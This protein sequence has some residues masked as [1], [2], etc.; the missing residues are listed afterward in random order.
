MPEQPRT[1]HIE[2]LGPPRGARGVQE[3][4]PVADL[5]DLTTHH[6]G[7]NRAIHMEDG[8]IRGAEDQQPTYRGGDRSYAYI[9]GEF[10]EVID[11]TTDR[12]GSLKPDQVL[13]VKDYILEDPAPP[14]G[15][16]ARAVG[17]PSPTAGYVSRVS[18]AGG[19]V[20]IMDREGGDVIARIR[21]LDPISV[22]EGDTV[23]YG[24]SLGTQ[25]NKGL[26]RNAGVH[27]HVEMDTAHHQQLVD[28]FDD[29]NSG[30]L[31]VQPE[32]RANTARPVVADGTFRLGQSDERIGDVQRVM[33]G[34]GY[35]A[36]DG[37]VLD[38]DGV[39][40]PN[41]QGALLDFQRDHGLPQ[42]GNI[43]P[44]TLDLAPP[45]PRRELDGE[46]G[47][48]A[49]QAPPAHAAP[50]HPDHPDHG[51]ALP[52]QPAPAVNQHRG[53]H[54][55]RAEQSQVVGE[56][57]A[58]DRAMFEKLRDRIPGHIS[59]DAVAAALHGAKKADIDSAE[60]I[61]DVRLAGDQIYVVGTTPGFRAVVDLSQKIPA[62]EESL[63]QTRLLN[64]AQVLSQ[65]QEDQN[66]QAR[67]GE[68]NARV[69]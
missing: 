30:R 9:D 35:R 42:T 22:R 33:A 21:H 24:E 64:Q 20:E 13:M 26:P 55:S 3:N 50:G 19:M 25:S 40:R 47:R 1:F 45:M 54:A 36:V 52:E 29:L 4:E 59:D 44:P 46:H 12:Y 34:E 49:Y 38:H 43:D 6:P 8:H 7:A 60:K 5:D 23:T 48:P 66:R 18:D 53:G 16:S 32:L 62:V 63:Q 58:H 2:Q 10:Q 27:A 67:A 51:R 31:S 61:A 17:V 37:G 57:S 56:L 15:T 39:Y 69:I 14:R 28:Y 11:H 68:N 41:M 65:Q